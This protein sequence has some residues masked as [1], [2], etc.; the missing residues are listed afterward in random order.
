VPLYG[1][2][3]SRVAR[4][5]LIN[6]VTAVFVACLAVF[7][8]LA[9]AGA[10]VGI[11]YFVWIGIF[12]MMLP[13]QF[14][15]FA[16]DV[17]SKDQGE[18]LFP[19]VGFGAS[20][21]AVLGAVV[22]GWLIVPLGLNQ[23]LLVGAGLLVLQAFI[24]NVVDFRERA[25]HATV[26]EAPP[27]V[28][29]GP[30]DTAARP[31][32]GA[33]GMVFGTPYL[34]MIAIMLMCLNWVNTTGEY[35][36]GSVVEDAAREAV[37]SGTAGGLSVEAYIGQFYSR[38]FGVVNIAGLLIQLF[39]VSRIIKYL[40][41]RFAVLVLPFIAFGA[42]NVLAFFPALT[43]VRWAKTAENS[44]DYS[45]NNTVR[46]MLFLPCTREQKYSAKQAIDSFFVRIGDVLSA[47]L[48]FMGTTYL[49]LGGSGFAKFSIGIV[50][51]WL[52]LAF[53]VGREYSRM[54]ALGRQPG[55]R[56]VGAPD[57]AAPADTAAQPG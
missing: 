3:A 54:A 37:A 28:V 53:A 13:A 24:T 10:A 19:I 4:R 41:V 56:L 1:R 33:F 7:Y 48:V 20:L 46:N 29:E 39:L 31:A 27:P 47:G 32:Q 15:A 11:V 16:N 6:T 34:L 49:A 30:T 5:R 26:V 43:I 25:Q 55:P 2:L 35:I 17:Y 23:L 57:E 18:R 22:A 38:F 52:V 50:A 42:Y 12:S 21:G 14:W 36:L 51:V 9:Q 8:I 44:T 40:G 45:L